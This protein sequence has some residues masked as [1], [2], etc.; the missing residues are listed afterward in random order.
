MTPERI[1]HMTMRALWDA[2]AE[3]GFYTVSTRGKTL[4]QEGFIHCALEDQIE[5]VADLVYRDW[6]DEL[7]LLVIDTAQVDAEIRLENL[8]GGEILFPHVYGP[9]PVRAVTA[10]VPMTK[11]ER[12][13]TKPTLG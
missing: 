12:G 8:Y 9:L 7:I 13:W 5:M 10:V 4:A 6:T 1:F 11:T 2:A 3:H